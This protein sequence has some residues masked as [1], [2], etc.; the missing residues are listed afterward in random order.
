[1]VVEVANM[2]PSHPLGLESVPTVGVIVLI[3]MCA[4]AGEEA[5]NCILKNTFLLYL[6][7]GLT[8]RFRRCFQGSIVFTRVTGI[9]ISLSLEIPCVCCGLRWTLQTPTAPRHFSTFFLCFTDWLHSKSRVMM[10]GNFS[11]FSSVF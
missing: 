3:I 8:A 4:Q 10:C 7:L 5:R 6:R 2:L 11:S 1:M 9:L